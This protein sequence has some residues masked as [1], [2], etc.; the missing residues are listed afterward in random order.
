MVNLTNNSKYKI[1][2]IIFLIVGLILLIGGM[3]A[4][5][6]YLDGMGK[7]EDNREY[8]DTL[9][10]GSERDRVDKIIEEN[11]EMFKI[12]GPAV[13]ICTP[14]GII[15]VIFGIVLLLKSK[16][17]VKMIN[18]GHSNNVSQQTT[19]QFNQQNIQDIKYCTNCGAKLSMDTKF[20]TECGKKNK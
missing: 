12:K 7:Q 6:T 3:W 20:C 1:G 18:Y 4:G 17:Q 8:R 15:L 2:G 11:E 5:I 19:Q 16:K 9:A 14:I 10:P 13:A